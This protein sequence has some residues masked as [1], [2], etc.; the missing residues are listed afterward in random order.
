M[1]RY[2]KNDKMDPRTAL[3]GADTVIYIVLFAVAIIGLILYMLS[4]YK[5]RMTGAIAVMLIALS[6]AYFLFML[7]VCKVSFHLSLFQRYFPISRD[8]VMFLY[9]FPL[10]RQTVLSLLNFF[11]IVFLFSNLWLSQVY[12]P[13]RLA[14]HSKA[15]IVSA[16]VFYCIQGILY[17][18]YLYPR[19]Y[20]ALY[21]QIMNSET[22]KTTYSVLQTVTQS[23]NITL[24]TACISSV[25]YGYIKAPSLKIVRNAVGV[26]LFAYA[27]LIITYMTFFLNLPKLLV[28]YSK[29]ADIITYQLIFLT[30]NL[31]FYG[32]Y[33]YILTFLV[34]L[35]IFSGYRLTH[36][37]RRLDTQS[38]SIAKNIE[39]VNMPTRIF[40]HFMKNEILSLAVELE[41]IVAETKDS[42]AAHSM[43]SH[44]NWLRS[45]L[46]D[47]YNNTREDVM[48]I[49]QIPLDQ[50][51]RGAID[52]VSAS[53]KQAGI[54]LSLHFPEE[55][56]NGFVDPQYLQ[57]ALLN[58]LQNA[59]EA[60]TNVKDDRKKEISI[61]LYPKLKWTIIEI[62][63]NAYGIPQEDLT[64]IFSP[65]FSTKPITQSWGIGLSLTHRI[66]TSM[67]GRIEVDSRMGK[68]TTFH[69][70]LPSIK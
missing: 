6:C 18:P 33:P 40:C 19:L 43:E 51:I 11:C 34:A 39:A 24:L 41:E 44:L 61:S 25:I 58:L 52:A 63:D 22:L 5:N 49:Q 55:I 10:Q 9:A 50:V 23:V 56:P 13:K 66:V 30:N 62:N 20:S 29:A 4:E 16:G 65:L 59:H 31:P 69:I 8:V 46:D 67:G 3:R 15:I 17:D 14:A 27:T 37:M 47:I 7:Y 42:E 1:R 28:D 68:G 45:R 70:L 64:S 48:Q 36:L 21:P 38:L 54:K 60:L 57:Q 53:L 32:L 2:N 26:F 12:W 35:L